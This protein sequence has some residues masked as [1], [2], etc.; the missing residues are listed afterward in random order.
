MQPVGTHSTGL[1]CLF[2]II[3]EHFL[4]LRHTKVFQL[5]IHFPCPI[6][7][8]AVFPGSLVTFSLDLG[9]NIALSPIWGWLPNCS[10]SDCYSR[11][12]PLFLFYLG[13]DTS[14]QT[15]LVHGGTPHSAGALFP[16]PSPLCC[17]FRWTVLTCLL[18]VVSQAYEC[19]MSLS[20]L[21]DT[22]C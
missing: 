19:P 5:I 14:L 3:L 8:S 13:L 9:A 2:Y 12:W 6:P 16:A 15:A 20:R 10:Q 17:Y 11:V 7:E 1:L 21:C 4:A 22:L 18:K